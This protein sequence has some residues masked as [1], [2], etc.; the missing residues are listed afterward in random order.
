MV[1]EKSNSLPTYRKTQK[2][3]CYDPNAMHRCGRMHLP[4]AP[5]CNIQCAYCIKEFDCVNESRP[6]ITSQILRPKEA[7]A[8]ISKVF[9]KFPNI[10]VIGIAGPGDPLFNEETFTTFSLIRNKYPAISFCLSTNGLLLPEKIQRLKELEITHITVTINTLDARTGANIYSYVNYKDK[11]FTGDQGAKIL[12]DNQLRGVEAAVASGLVVKINTVMIP[13]INDAEITNIARK[14]KDMG[15]YMHNV[16]PL[17]PQYKYA[18][19]PPPSKDELKAVRHECAIHI[20]QMRHCRQ[21]RADAVGNLKND[22][23][24][25]QACCS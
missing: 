9:A 8:K 6:G 21:C 19:I 12:I 10:T 24:F 3:P 11:I 23:I 14:A 20:K 25:E 7:T 16:L 4:V 18:H 1:L 5:R 22:A 17:I 13:T 2:H 15:A